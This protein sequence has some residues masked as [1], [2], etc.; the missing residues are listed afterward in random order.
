MA[1]N[2]ATME[3]CICARREINFLVVLELVFCMKVYAF[4]DCVL[5]VLYQ[6][7]LVPCT[8]CLPAATIL[9]EIKLFENRNDI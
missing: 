2:D 8:C 4:L 5:C 6:L 7:S 9:L 1:I 3:V